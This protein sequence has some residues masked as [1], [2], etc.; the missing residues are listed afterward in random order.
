[1]R[2]LDKHSRTTSVPL[3]RKVW[4][5]D[6]IFFEEMASMLGSKSSCTTS[7]WNPRDFF[8]VAVVLLSYNSLE[9]PEV[10]AN[11][12]KLNISIKFPKSSPRNYSKMDI[13]SWP[14]ITPTCSGQYPTDHLLTEIQ[15][16]AFTDTLLQQKHHHSCRK[17]N[18][19]LFLFPKLR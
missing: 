11:P 18:Q 16:Q 5:F 12:T 6:A 2:R 4:I 10:V 19:V 13:W 9:N 3:C 17:I 1:M 15:L 7:S 8:A 14:M